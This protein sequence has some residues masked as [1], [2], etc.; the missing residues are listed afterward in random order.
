MCNLRY[1]HHIWSGTEPHSDPPFSSPLH[2]DVQE[3]TVS[4]VG[5]YT[6]EQV[7]G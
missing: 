2:V 4:S 6:N 5:V 1:P 3:P 7:T